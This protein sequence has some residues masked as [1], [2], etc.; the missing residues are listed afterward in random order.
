MGKEVS[1]EAEVNELYATIGQLTVERDFCITEVRAMTRAERVTMIA[2]DRADLSVRRQCALL[3]LARSGVYHEPA[4]Q[5][6]LLI[7][8]SVGPH[9][10]FTQLQASRPA[11]SAPSQ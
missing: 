5:L 11:S 10:R 6:R 3:R 9:S 2:R 8:R 4:A 7:R 1:R